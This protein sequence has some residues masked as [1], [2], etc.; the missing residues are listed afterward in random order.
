MV[1]NSAAELQAFG[2]KAKR[3]DIRLSFHPSHFV[4]L[5]SPDPKLVEKGIWDL[6]SQLRSW[7]SWSSARKRCW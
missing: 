4:V 7:T 5:N 3:L 1:R 6:L 2:A